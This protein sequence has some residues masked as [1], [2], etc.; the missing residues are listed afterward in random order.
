MSKVVDAQ[1]ESDRPNYFVIVPNSLPKF[2]LVIREK[3]RLFE[4]EKHFFETQRMRITVVSLVLI[5]AIF[6]ICVSA[7]CSINAIF[8]QN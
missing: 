3:S 4:G 5:V 7:M 8:F 1:F 6:A 2:Y